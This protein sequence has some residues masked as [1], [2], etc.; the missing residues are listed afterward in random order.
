LAGRCWATPSKVV[1]LPHCVIAA[2]LPELPE[3]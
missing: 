2:E 3:Q 1:I